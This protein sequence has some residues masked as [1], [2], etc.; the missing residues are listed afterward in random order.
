MRRTASQNNAFS[1]G[2][3]NPLGSGSGALDHGGLGHANSTGVSTTGIT[4]SNHSNGTAGHGHGTLG[5]VLGNSP[6]LA[7]FSLSQMTRSPRR[8]SLNP[9]DH[10]TTSQQDHVSSMQTPL[11]SPLTG[12]KHPLQHSCE[13]EA[14]SYSTKRT[15]MNSSSSSAEWSSGSRTLSYDISSGYNRQGSSHHNYENG[16]KELGSFTTVELF[17]RYF[18]WIERPHTMENSANYHLFKDGIKP[19][20]EHPANVNGGR[21]IVTLLQKNAE[22]LDRCWM[23]LAYALVGEQLDA[24]DDICGAVLSRRKADRLAVWVRDK[25]D[26]EAINGVGKRLIKILDL[27]KEMITLEFQ[28]TTDPRSSGIPK[29]FIT[30]ETIRMDLA[31]EALPAV[32]ALSSS[33]TDTSPTLSADSASATPVSLVAPSPATPS[34]NGFENGFTNKDNPLVTGATGLLISVDG[35]E[36]H[37]N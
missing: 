22:L 6:Q 4:S 7:P 1:Y 34:S 19:M 16:L 27:A 25:E 2:L 10:A 29:S 13:K 14:A 37:F 21:W 15:T 32:M 8:S 28:I 23:E 9:P 17:A 26:V 20:W 5:G 36:D 18:N 33:E 31:R 30:L 11:P 3:G 12:D 35:K 24:G